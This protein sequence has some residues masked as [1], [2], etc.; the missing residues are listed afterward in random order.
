[1]ISIGNNHTNKIV[2][3][4]NIQFQN[5]PTEIIEKIIVYIP[6][7]DMDKEI[8]NFRLIS[9]SINLVILSSSS[10]RIQNIF[11][12]FIK[13]LI[14]SNMTVKEKIEKLSFHLNHS[15]LR[16]A[17]GYGYLAALQE[18]PPIADYIYEQ[19]PILI[20][21]K[22]IDSLK[23]LFGAISLGHLKVVK[24]V[25]KKYELEHFDSYLN[26]HFSLAILR[27]LKLNQLETVKILLK[28]N[29]FSPFDDYDNWLIIIEQITELGDA[30]LIQILIDHPEF[31]PTPFE[32][33][34][35]SKKGF[36]NFVQ[37][38]L[39]DERFDLEIFETKCEALEVAIS[40]GHSEVV[41]LL[42]E[43]GRFDPSINNCETL[44]DA[45]KRGLSEIV[46]LLLN[47]VR[48]ENAKLQDAFIGAVEYG[49]SKVVQIFLDA[50]VDP[51]ADNNY[52][53]RCAVDMGNENLVNI[54][55][56]DERIEPSALHN[57][58]IY[59]ATKKGFVKITELL[60]NHKRFDPYLIREDHYALLYTSMIGFNDKI[61]DLLMQGLNPASYNNAA[62]QLA[63]KN[64]HK[65][66]VKTLLQDERVDPTA[67]DNYAL[68][69]AIFYG[70]NEVTDLLLKHPKMDPSL[71]IKLL[72]IKKKR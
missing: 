19:E 23:L 38:I 48:I 14:L 42:L 57:E 12:Y 16:K 41:K 34:Y 68:R 18:Y 53:L 62:I 66:I 10:K 70:Y 40:N 69:T 27:A 22:K 44:V 64:N 71:Y 25:S 54:L 63:V 72:N 28:N 50:G 36:V 35:F 3:Y 26:E 56:K 2:N 67:N 45:S 65:D 29:Q 21:D 39:K 24:L 51:S 11:Q 43:D 49:H 13:N 1:M 31:F 33:Y 55:L 46:K 4:E 60:L 15:S 61:N 6:L 17:F 7:H 47:D 20:F 8:C 5:L 9:K 32:L 58:A 52:A 37:K 30:E 59:K